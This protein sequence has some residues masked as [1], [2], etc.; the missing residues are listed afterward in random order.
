MNILPV[1]IEELQKNKYD[2]II[3][4][5]PRSGVNFLI[6][7]IANNF[8][9]SFCYTHKTPINKNNNIITIIRNPKESIASWISMGLHFDYYE[10]RYKD[11]N[12]KEYIDGA[13][14]KYIM[15]YEYIYKS[16][17]HIIKFENLIN[18]PKEEIL[19]ISQKFNIEVNKDILPSEVTDD[20][21]NGRISSSKDTMFYNFVLEQLDSYD[22]ILCNKKYNDIL[23]K[24]GL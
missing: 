15:F 10:D 18:N 22:L 23:T 13:I 8:D 5:Y 14:K 24:L 17:D 20:V 4:T 12:V 3:C 21:E 19:K 11:T 2:L 7:H 9:L 16:A 6:N 1:G